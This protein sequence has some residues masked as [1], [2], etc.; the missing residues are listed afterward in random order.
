MG[1]K[2][3]LS[4]ACLVSLLGVASCSN[5]GGTDL[6]NL[7]ASR[8]G[9]DEFSILPTKPLQT[10]ESYAAL[11]PPTPGGSNLT[12]PTPKSD[13]IIALG[14]RP[15]AGVVP[16]QAEIN[17]VTRFGVD[18]NIRNTLAREDLEWRQKNNG[19]ILERLLNV[20]VYFKAYEKMTL[21]QYKELERWRAAGRKT[22]SAPPDPTI[23]YE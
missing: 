15:G 10:P 8:E 20:N 23:E 18:Q 17:Y 4:L 13:A 19:R 9:P 11:P 5:D 21:D 3:S 2:A 12:D 22:P 14:G 7:A 1:L 16:S 6:L